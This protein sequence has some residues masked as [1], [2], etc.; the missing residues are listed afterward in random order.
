MKKHI[1]LIV[2]LCLSFSGFSAPMPN[3][4][5]DV[6]SEFPKETYLARLGSGVTIENAQA[7]ALSQLASYFNSQIVVDTKTTNTMTNINDEVQ[8]EQTLNQEVNVVSEINLVG[9]EYSKSFYDK[10]Q[11]KYYIVAYMNRD[12]AWKNLEDKLNASYE[13]FENYQDLAD[14]SKDLILK[15]K[16]SKKANIA[17]EEFLNEIYNAFLI[18]PAKRK[19]YKS[20]INGINIKIEENAFIIIPISFNVSGDFENIISASVSNEFKKAGFTV[21]TDSDKQ[22]SYV[23]NLQINSNEK[24]EDDIHFIYPEVSLALTDVNGLKTYYSFE[25]KWGKTAG[26]SLP[27]AQ[28]KAFQKISEELIDTLSKDIKENLFEN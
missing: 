13:K 24:I 28:K 6:D 8:K 2:L 3:W 10:K 19:E 18:N 9:V 11:K 17:G 21:N 27:Q 5:L 1:I 12:E 23:V 25:N 7:N 16:Y 20:K 26:F 15:Y 14:G 22:G 4:V